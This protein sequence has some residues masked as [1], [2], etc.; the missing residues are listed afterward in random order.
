[1][2][3]RRAE[4]RLAR[5]DVEGTL[6]D[7][8]K[9]VPLARKARDPQQRVPWLAGSAR[10]LFELGH[11]EE[12]RELAR[13]ALGGQGAGTRRWEL[14]DLALVASRLGF[15]DELHVALE[16]AAQTTWVEA[17]QA[18]LAGDLV[19]AADMFEQIGDAQLE[20]LSRLRAAELLVADGRHGEA[21]VQLRRALAFWST[22]RATRYIREAEELLGD[23][24]EIPA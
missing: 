14:G 20:A 6:A 22:V 15:S 24:S 16:Q 12:A 17:A 13:E 1:M 8:R 21:G 11:I 3:L 4:V 10:L 5:D 2:R 18:A 19:R 9:V 7:I 23:V